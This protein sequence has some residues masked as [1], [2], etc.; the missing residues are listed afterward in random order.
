MPYLQEGQLLST[1]SLHLDNFHPVRSA[2]H[3]TFLQLA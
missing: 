2:K 1:V 3:R